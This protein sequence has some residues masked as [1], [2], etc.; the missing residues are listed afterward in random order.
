MCLSGQLSVG[1]ICL[2]GVLVKS[3][4]NA[5]GEEAMR[6]QVN[7]R[8]KSIK[9]MEPDSVWIICPLQDFVVHSE[10]RNQTGQWW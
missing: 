4:L 5:R 6:F 2:K 9:G 1:L 10:E 3:N 7:V 8:L